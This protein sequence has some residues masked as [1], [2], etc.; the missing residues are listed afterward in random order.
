MLVTALCETDRGKILE[1]IGS[2]RKYRYRFVEPMMQPF[3]L[4]HGLR[5]ELITHDLA[6]TS[7]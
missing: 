7:K 4:M 2:E 6:A 1:Q 5:E 3:I